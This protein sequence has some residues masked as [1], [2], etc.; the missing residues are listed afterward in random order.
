MQIYSRPEKVSMCLLLGLLA[1]CGKQM[2]RAGSGSVDSLQAAAELSVETSAADFAATEVAGS[3]EGAGPGES[4]EKYD[5]IVDNPFLRVTDNP[6]STFSI[7]VDTASYSKVRQY[8]VDYNQLPRPDAVRI[9]ELLNYFPYQY[10]S[11]SGDGTQ[12]FAAYAD[13]S[14]CPWNGSHRL[15][16]LAL[17]GRE[18]DTG[19]RPASN[20]V[21]LIDSSG[22]MKRPNKLPLLKLG[23]RLLL[24]QLNEQDRIGIVAY[25]GSAGLVLDSTPAS[26]TRAITGR[27]TASKR[28]GAPMA[29]RDWGLPIRSL[30]TI[31]SK[32]VPTGCCFAPMVTS[33]S[34]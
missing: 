18:I 27:S 20:L 23:M 13:V 14:Q 1:G 25:A 5:R 15:V 30:A 24:E 16:R 31:S 33:M 22:S 21:L 8:L 12:P 17:K 26:Q 3:D 11:P 6:L 9:E 4:G 28:V 34:A 7:D 19:D 32:A 2:P 10:A 29:A